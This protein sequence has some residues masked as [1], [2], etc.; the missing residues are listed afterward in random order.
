MGRNLKT[1]S[2]YQDSGLDSNRSGFHLSLFIKAC[3]RGVSQVVFI[4]N[5]WTGFFILGGLFLNDP[6]VSFCGI[7]GLFF[8]T[9]FA[10][11]LDLDKEEWKSG[12][13]G[14]NGFLIG[15]ALGTFQI[16]K[17]NPSV[18]FVMALTLVLSSLTLLLQIFLEAFFKRRL[19]CSGL[20]FPFNIVF[21]IFI[22][23]TIRYGQLPPPFKVTISNE[24]SFYFLFLLEGVLRGVSQVFLAES[25]Y[26]GLF[27]ISGMLIGSLRLTIFALLGSSLGLL[28]ALVLGISKGEI[29]S[30]IWQYNVVLSCMGIGGV[31][32]SWSKRL[33][34]FCSLCGLFT[35]LLTGFLIQILP[36]GFPFGTLPFCLGTMKF[37]VVLNQ[38]SKIKTKEI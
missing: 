29:I 6:W 8:S 38:M 34:F 35:A 11:F 12:L 33:A 21:F 32:Y 27:I 9:L 24:G 19:Q 23:G 36:G 26:S 3:L 1:S 31:F 18:F 22:I 25:L 17:E 16:F 4:K 5:S 14:F 15:L 7:M 30:G 28:T 20:T 2:N 37:I 10:N 13:F